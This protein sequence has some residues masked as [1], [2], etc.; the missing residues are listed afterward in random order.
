MIKRICDRCGE[1][2]EGVYQK[3]TR[4]QVYMDSSSCFNTCLLNMSPTTIIYDLCNKCIEDFNDFIAQKPLIKRS[5]ED[6]NQNL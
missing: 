3:L 1:E 6:E 5:E 4:E 2:I